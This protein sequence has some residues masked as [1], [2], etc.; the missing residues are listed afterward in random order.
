MSVPQVRSGQIYGY[1]AHGPFEPDRGLRFDAQKLLLDPYGRAVAVPR[2]YDRTAASRPGDNMAT[3]MK[4][5]VTD[6][7]GYDW[8]GD[9]P[10]RHPY[11]STVIYEMHVAGFTRHP[12]S[13]VA[14]GKRGTYAGLIEKIPYLQDLG[15]TAVELLP[16]FQFDPFDAPPGR[17]NYW[18]YC[19]ISFF[20]P[21]LAYSSRPDPLAAID[22]FRDM[23]K[24]LH[25]A[26]IEV[27]L[28]V[29]YNHTAEGNQE[30]ADAVFPRPGELGLLHA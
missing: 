3:A 13:G 18:G 21:H 29:V 27:I 6:S 23:V 5:V 30:R 8:E 4:S 9:R 10:L 1:R 7:S 22:E 15:I 2:A 20:A 25:R 14:P 19:P 26:G 24:A 12:N 17:M 28:D 16:V 11:A